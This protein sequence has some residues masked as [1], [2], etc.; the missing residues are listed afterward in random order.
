MMCVPLLACFA[1]L[2][3]MFNDDDLGREV[4]SGWVAQQAVG[5]G[6]SASPKEVLG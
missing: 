4:G 1:W 5:C 2:M 6:M 3:M